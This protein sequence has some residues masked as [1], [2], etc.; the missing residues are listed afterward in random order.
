MWNEGICAE[1][2]GRVRVERGPVSLV[3]SAWLGGL[4]QPQ[5]CLEAAASV[6]AILA[7][8][9]AS[10][11][12]LSRPWPEGQPPM[13]A[14]DADAPAVAAVPFRM[15]EAAKE[16]GH[17]EMTPFCA[18]AGAVADVLADTVFAALCG[19]AAQPAAPVRVVVSNGGDVAVRLTPGST[20]SVGLVPSLA[21]PGADAVVTLRAEDAVRGVATSGF[22][23]RGLTQ[24]VADAVTVFAASGA[25]ADALATRLGNASRLPAS[26][27]VRVAPAGSLRCPCDIADLPVTVRVD[28]LTPEEKETAL[29]GIRAAAAPLLASGKLQALRATVQGRS[30][31][32][33]DGAP[34]NLFGG[35]HVRTDSQD[36]D[37][38]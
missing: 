4:P 19:T 3:V 27:R 37:R 5:A 24:G 12:V 11:P 33:P 28:A 26:P 34:E 20:C 8:I 25:R 16:T 32:L 1:A 29:A 15:W 14:P 23:G 17:P 21:A 7:T 22:G 13:P 2:S 6:D 18:V 9:T 31:W 30:L 36:R 35:F 38:C 10:L